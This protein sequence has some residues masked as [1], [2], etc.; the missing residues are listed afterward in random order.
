M[1][2]FGDFVAVEDDY[3]DESATVSKGTGRTS[4]VTPRNLYGGANANDNKKSSSSLKV[5]NTTSS[6]SKRKFVF[7]SRELLRSI[8]ACVQGFEHNHDNSVLCE[9]LIDALVLRVGGA[10]SNGGVG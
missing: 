6:S 10:E 7:S 4:G 2:D 3:A 8:D 1:D 5:K 9:K